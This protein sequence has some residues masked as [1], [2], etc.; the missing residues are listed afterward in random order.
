MKE[1]LPESRL[2]NLH[3]RANPMDFPLKVLPL[4]LQ[5]HTQTG[6]EYLGM[7]LGN[8]GNILELYQPF[9]YLGSDPGLP[10]FL[11]A[12]VCSD[13]L[14]PQHHIDHQPLCLKFPF[15]RPHLSGGVRLKA[16]WPDPVNN[17]KPAPDQG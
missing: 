4:K 16:T 2:K 7:L 6:M 9:L 17:P 15:C 10:F 3:Q 8:F 1:G 5:Q 13:V 11:W 12:H 14:T